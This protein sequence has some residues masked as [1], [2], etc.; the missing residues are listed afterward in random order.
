MA[1]I[2]IGRDAE[3]NTIFSDDTTPASPYT[4]SR[5]PIAVHNH[6]VDRQRIS[7][8]AQ[9]RQVQIAREDAERRRISAEQY[10]QQ[11]R[12]EA[13][14]KKIKKWM[15]TGMVAIACVLTIGYGVI[16]DWFTGLIDVLP[17][18][19]QNVQI[20]SATTFSAGWHNYA[21][22]TRGN[23]WIWDS[24]EVPRFNNTNWLNSLAILSDVVAVSSRWNHSMA[25]RAD[26]TLWGRG[27]NWA[28]ALGDGTTTARG[29]HVFV[30]DNVINVS[31]GSFFTMAIRADNTL[32]GWGNNS[33]GQL[34][35]GTTTNS[36][37]PVM[38][39]EDVI[40]VAA[41]SQHTMAIRSDGSLWGWGSNRNGML[42]D[43]TITNQYSPIYIM[44]D[45]VSVAAGDGHTLAITSEGTLW[46]WGSNWSGQLGNVEITDDYIVTPIRIMD[47]VSAIA[48]GMNH[49]MVIMD[50][51]T[52]W[53]WGGNDQGQL[54]TGVESDMFARYD[55]AMIL[56]NV[57]SISVAERQT[58]ALRSD[59]SLWSWGGSFLG[60]DN[61]VFG[62]HTPIRIR[63]EVL[64]PNNRR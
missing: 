31:A 6:D 56:D 42:G 2:P 11:Q 25:I 21:V 20:V 17:I 24:A 26:G 55:P 32:W 18:G 30:M 34:G 61:I 10:I 12:R 16:N 35:D 27:N 60:E 7:T 19:T 5:R 50:D 37:N 64:M 53:S 52:L 59:G 54:G 33:S 15:F 62:Q 49:S 39:M 14:N 41:G 48:A 8:L 4:S 3:G 47:G 38:I 46:A 51:R 28:G 1:R 57:V 9:Q 44:S 45:V 40:Y 22:D 23:L 58:M 43:G 36:Y 63:T 13:K 29:N